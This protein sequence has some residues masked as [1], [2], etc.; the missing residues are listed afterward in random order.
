MAVNL[1]FAEYEEA[2]RLRFVWGVAQGPVSWDPV[3]W[4]DKVPWTPI[5]SFV[6]NPENIIESPS[7]GD[8][9]V[10]WD[11]SFDITSLEAQEWML[12][13]CRTLRESSE[14]A[15]RLKVG[16]CNLKVFTS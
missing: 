2:V 5:L 16:W 6:K 10:D 15:G 9:G 11:P 14:T 7:D 1:G 13:F 4:E 12:E 8:E 3:S